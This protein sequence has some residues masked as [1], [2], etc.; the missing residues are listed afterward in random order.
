MEN[1]LVKKNDDYEIIFKWTYVDGGTCRVRF[2]HPCLARCFSI[3]AKAAGISMDIELSGE[4]K[5][6][7]L[8]MADMGEGFAEAVSRKCCETAGARSYRGTG[9]GSLNDGWNKV[10]CELSL[11]GRVGWVYEVLS[12]HTIEDGLEASDFFGSLASHAGLQL[13]FRIHDDSRECGEK[14]F[15]AFGEALQEAFMENR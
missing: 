14:M 4:V 3:F 11:P 6:W 9:F 10:N 12:E 5:N 2:E 15:A 1:R 8:F 7:K 13:R